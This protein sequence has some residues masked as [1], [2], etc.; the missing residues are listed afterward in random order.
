MHAT[1]ATS[2][3]YNIPLSAEFCNKLHLPIRTLIY[4]GFPLRMARSTAEASPGTAVSS[5][6]ISRAHDCS[7]LTS[8]V[9]L[10]MI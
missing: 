10:R 2:S 6:P 7:E 8:S 4:F 5:G 1:A 9:M 3:C